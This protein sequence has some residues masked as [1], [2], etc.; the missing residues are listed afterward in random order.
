MSTESHYKDIKHTVHITTDDHVSCEQCQDNLGYNDIANAIN[1]YIN[2][3]NYRLLHVGQETTR[4]QTEGKIF[5]LT[6]AI[7]GK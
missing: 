3:H 2:Q 1:H 6:A 7:L 4:E 5:H